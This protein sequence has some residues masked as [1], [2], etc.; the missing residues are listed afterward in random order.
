ME[1]E[2]NKVIKTYK[3][4]NE[5]LQC[6]GF[7]YE[8]GKT[9]EIPEGEKISLCENGFHAVDGDV[10]PLQVFDYYEPSIN[11]NR[12]R[13]CEVEVSG[14]TASD[15]N[16][17]VGSKIKIGAEIGIPGLIRAHFE[18]VKRHIT[19]ENN[20]EACQP[21]TAGSYGA[22]TAG[23]SG[24]AT[25]GDSGRA[26]RQLRYQGMEDLGCGRRNHQGRYLV[27]LERR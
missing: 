12:S 5:N 9:Y 24:A 22:A 26:R 21:A 3:G 20:A 25:A 18:W 6:R 15:G 7:Q 11:G 2:D 23:D 14:R 16:K 1:N 8:V 13:Y 27:H 19:N 10:S 17:V 4:F